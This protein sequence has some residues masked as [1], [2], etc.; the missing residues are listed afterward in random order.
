L[1]LVTCDR[2]NRFHANRRGVRSKT[3]TASDGRR[4]HWRNASG[5]HRTHR[6]YRPTRLTTTPEFSP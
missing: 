1:M 4:E 3:E 2:E 6:T 5:T